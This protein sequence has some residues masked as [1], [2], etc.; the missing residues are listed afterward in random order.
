[1]QKEENKSSQ[2]NFEQ[3]AKWLLESFERMHQEM[4]Q[5]VQQ[6]QAVYHLE[7]ATIQGSVIGGNMVKNAS[8]NY[9]EK[10]ERKEKPQYSD[11]QIAQALVSINGKEKVLS[12][13]QLWLGACCFLMQRCGYSRNFER[14]CEQIAT[15]PYG[16]EKL[17]IECKYN[18][19]RRLTYLK[20]V[21]QGIE[22]WDDYE[23][24]EGEKKLFFG[25]QNVV[26]ELEK[27]L[28]GEE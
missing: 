26:K 9:G 10:T 17:E 24:R 12:N 2:D 3:L 8:D 22:F 21:K 5:K 25:C 13:Y 7:G 27:K 28:N 23:P 20:F 16:D 6:P 18:N 14:C 11:E 4:M 1:M 19:I 15:L